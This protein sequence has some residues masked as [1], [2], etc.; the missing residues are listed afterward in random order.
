M[1]GYVASVAT[2]DLKIRAST[3]L[4]TMS[5]DLHVLGDKHSMTLVEVLNTALV[6]LLLLLIE[7]EIDIHVHCTLYM[8]LYS[9]DF[10]VQG[11]QSFKLWHRSVLWQL[12]QS[13]CPTF[14]NFVS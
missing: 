14:Q 11:V 3:R 9:P 5:I 1:R 8:T 13:L 12:T 6:S 2:R 10:S 4:V 7:A